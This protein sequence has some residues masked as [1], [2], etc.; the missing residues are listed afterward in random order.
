MYESTTRH[1]VKGKIIDSKMMSGFWWL[2]YKGNG[3]GWIV[4]VQ[5]IFREVKLL[6]QDI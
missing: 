6:L 5:G 1:S 2:E 4:E 3:K